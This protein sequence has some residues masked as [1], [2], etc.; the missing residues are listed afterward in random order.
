[1]K[2]RSTE[3]EHKF[4]QTLFTE[5][6]IF[7]IQGLTLSA[8]HNFTACIEAIQ[9]EDNETINLRAIFPVLDVKAKH[10][11]STVLA[12]PFY[13]LIYKNGHYFIH[14]VECNPE[15]TFTTIADFNEEKFIEWWQ[16]IKGQ[17]QTKEV[18]E[19]QV[20]IDS[21]VF[22]NVLAKYKLAWGGN[23]DGYMFKEKHI[24]CIIENIY[25]QKNPL[26]S[27]KGDPYY[28]F[29]GKGPN[30]NTWY[31]TVKLASILKIPLFLFTIQGNSDDAKIG[32][33]IIE[34]LSTEE[35][36]YLDG[37]FPHKN[38]IEGK[39]NIKK[40]ILSKLNV[41]APYIKS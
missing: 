19:A 30:Y 36:H 33:A 31:P 38:I 17:K 40:M 5:L 18:F 41:K 6:N 20:R 4:T 32:F 11:L 1:M 26:D 8:D 16:K 22:D 3:R 7:S 10:H 2:I 28:Y 25:T 35:I 29:K 9:Y 39:D 14:Q 23:I 34:H 15:P 24:A 37:I 12:I 21:S 27:P 13:Y